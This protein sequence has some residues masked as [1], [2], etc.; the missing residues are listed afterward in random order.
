MCC[1]TCLRCLVL[2][3]V[4]SSIFSYVGLVLCW[5]FACICTGF[6]VCEVCHG[7][8]ACVYR[9]LCFWVVPIRFLCPM[10]LFF[11]FVDLAGM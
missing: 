10:S 5:V 11:V 9:V 6:L 4:V 3:S 1:V 8:L 2:A 7:V